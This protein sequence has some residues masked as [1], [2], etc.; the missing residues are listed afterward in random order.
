MLDTVETNRCWD[1]INGEDTVSYA[2]REYPNLEACD[3]KRNIASAKALGE[4][5]QLV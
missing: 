4:L 2:A 3:M 1:I 5:A